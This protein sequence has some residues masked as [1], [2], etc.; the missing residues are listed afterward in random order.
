VLSLSLVVAD[1]A[2]LDRFGSIYPALAVYALARAGTLLLLSNMRIKRRFGRMFACGVIEA[3]VLST[4]LLLAERGSLGAIGSIYALSAL[5]VLAFALA[6]TEDVRAGDGWRDEEWVRHLLGGVGAGALVNLLNGMQLYLSRIA[7]GMNGDLTEVAVFYA[8]ASMANL[9]V[10][11]VTVLSSLVLSLLGGRST[12]GMTRR[13]RRLYFIG[14]FCVSTVVGGAAYYGGGW[15]IGNR[16]PDLAERAIL[17]YHWLAMGSG[18]LSLLI[19]TRPLVVKF[20]DLGLA[21]RVATICFAA[22]VV[23]LALLVPSLGGAGAALA[24][25]LSCATG[26]VAW[27]WMA[28]RLG[29]ATE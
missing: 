13:E 15:L 10:V 1:H 20:G 16:F 3:V 29:E 12:N 22:Q 27:I 2:V 8:G 6:S 4:I 18:A 11:P 7:L 9:F 26:A 28:V 23:T 25:F 19:M 5:L 17:F 14:S 24:Q 21:A